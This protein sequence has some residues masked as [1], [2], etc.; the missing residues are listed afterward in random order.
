MARTVADLE[1]VLSVIW[2]PDGLDTRIAPIPLAPS[3]AVTLKGL[4]C[5]VMVDNG[6]AT[7]G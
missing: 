4:R 1:L 5:A 2:G 6:V 7:P 3:S